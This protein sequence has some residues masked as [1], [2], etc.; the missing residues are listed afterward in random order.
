MI[1]KAQEEQMEI[2]IQ[3]LQYLDQQKDLEQSEN[4]SNLLKLKAFLQRELE[5]KNKL[6]QE[7][8]NLEGRTAE[9]SH[10]RTE[11]FK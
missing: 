2:Y 11:L 10:T 8:K 6:D 9:L 7:V 1:L 3:Q 5:K 4:E